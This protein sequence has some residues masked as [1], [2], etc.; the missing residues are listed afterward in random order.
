MRWSCVALWTGVGQREVRWSSDG[1]KD[2]GRGR[3]REDRIGGDGGGVPPGANRFPA[4]L[5]RLLVLVPWN[6]VWFHLW[7]ITRTE[8]WPPFSTQ[9]R[10]T[11]AT[12]ILTHTYQVGQSCAH[13]HCYACTRPRWWHALINPHLAFGIIQNLNWEI[14][15][16]LLFW[17]YETIKKTAGLVLHTV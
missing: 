5:K 4:A 8:V 17:N 9:H 15:L 7:Q 12:H 2:G 1:W 11:P 13:I 16:F 3:E 10:H 6:G 14:C